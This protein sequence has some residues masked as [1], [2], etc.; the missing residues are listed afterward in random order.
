MPFKCICVA[1]TILFLVST[2]F[3][4][5]CPKVK[6][7]KVAVQ[8]LL[9]K[10]ASST[11][12]DRYCVDDALDTLGSATEF[13]NKNYIKFL[14]GMLDFERWTPDGYME[15]SEQKYPA[16]NMLVHLQQ[17]GKNVAPYLINGIKESDSEVLRTNAAET[18]Y[19]TIR[20]CAALR[21]L[22]REDEREDIPYEQKLRLE[23]AAKHIYD[24]IVNQP[25]E[26]SSSTP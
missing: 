1:I 2:G 8:Y 13:R 18:L 22:S 10:K 20:G 24:W 15:A 5:E 19:Y 25:C 16:M 3:S 4:Q 6:N 9:G 11:A 26:A 14:A 12:A 7:E 21:L 23:A 17:S